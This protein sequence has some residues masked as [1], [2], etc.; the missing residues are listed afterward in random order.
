MEWIGKTRTQGVY[1]RF[2][3]KSWLEDEDIKYTSRKKVEANI[4]NH[5]YWKLC[6]Y[7]QDAEFYDEKNGHW[8]LWFDWKEIEK[9]IKLGK[10]D[11]EGNI[12]P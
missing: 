12:I 11:G 9:H 4:R 1:M 2:V 10:V 7:Q 6:D 5:F 3:M 8:L